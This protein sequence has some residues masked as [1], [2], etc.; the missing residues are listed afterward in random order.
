MKRTTTGSARGTGDGEKGLKPALRNLRWRYRRERARL[1]FGK[2]ALET[3]PILFGNSFPKSGTHLLAQVFQAF[4]Q[5]GLAI[6]PGMGPVLTFVAVNGRRRSSE[7]ILN[8]LRRFKPGDMGFGHVVAAPEIR[9]YWC[10][11]EVIHFF[12][13][14]DPRDVVVS[15]AFFIT[16]KA[17]EN[18][19]HQYYKSLSGF[20]ERLSAS[21]LGRPEWGDG[22]PNVYQRFEAF[23][24][25]MACPWVCTLRFEDFITRRD[26]AI[27]AMLDYAV[28]RGFRLSIPRQAAVDQLAAAIDP[29]RSY[30]FRSGKVGEWRTHFT[31][32]HKRQFKQVAGDLLVRLG[33]EQDSGW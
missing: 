5:T 7:E 13:I 3:A 14:R 23:L 31:E 12:M 2:N 30:T 8:D 29:K 1:R 20:E 15:H 18:V 22:F 32:S 6:D 9:E 21:I 17:T 28:G 19:H 16:D 26:Q 24:D 11:A 27:A 33:Y 4:P 10:R 25:W